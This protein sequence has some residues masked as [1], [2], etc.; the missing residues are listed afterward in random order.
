MRGIHGRDG[1]TGLPYS[2]HRACDPS[3]LVHADWHNHV[4]L[5]THLHEAYSQDRAQVI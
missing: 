2:G 5:E 3:T 1:T 4:W